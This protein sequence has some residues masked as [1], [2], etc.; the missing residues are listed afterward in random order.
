[1][2][3]YGSSA[4]DDRSVAQKTITLTNWKR[5]NNTTNIFENAQAAVWKGYIVVVIGNSLQ[6]LYFY[7]VD[8]EIWS[9]VSTVIPSSDDTCTCMCPGHTLTTHEAKLI[10]LSTSGDV[11]ELRGNKWIMHPELEVKSFASQAVCR[12]IFT[13]SSLD[14]N[15]LHSLILLASQDD[16]SLHTLQCFQ[17]SQWSQPRALQK[18]VQVFSQPNSQ[19]HQGR[20]RYQSSYYAGYYHTSFAAMKDNIYVSNGTQIYSINLQNPG[21][22]TIPVEE[23]PKLQLFHYTISAVDGTLFAFGGKDEDDQVSSDI[24]RYNSSSEIWEPAGYMRNAQYSALVTPVIENNV[25]V[26]G[27]ILG[28]MNNECLH[29]HVVESCEVHKTID[30]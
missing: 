19:Y 24:H 4:S 15:A 8:H 16:Q 30:N 14:D 26:I 21:A 12:A 9:N 5:L 6:T 23:I 10:L 29:S 11:Y 27:G 18:I 2:A 13:S 1:M 25:F 22:E 17:K 3:T 28:R 7:H 20:S